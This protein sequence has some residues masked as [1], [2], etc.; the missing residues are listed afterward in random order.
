MNTPKQMA[1]VAA[2]FIDALSDCTHG[3]VIGLSGELG[4]GKT[5]FV[6]AFLEELGVKERVLSPTFVLRRSYDISNSRLAHRFS[7]VAHVDAYRIEKPEELPA[8]GIPK[9]MEEKTTLLLMEWPEKIGSTL[10]NHAEYIGTLKFT[11]INEQ[12]RRVTLV[13]STQN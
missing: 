4:A 3:S 11:H 1:E 12:T 13:P 2:W 9:D 7:K 10:T 6:Q 5:T 8:T